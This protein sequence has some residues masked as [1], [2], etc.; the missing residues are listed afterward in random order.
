MNP[1]FAVV[2]AR[3]EP[4]DLEKLRRAFLGVP[5]LTPHDAD[6]VGGEGDAILCRNLSA[7]QA[8]ML[9]AKLQAEG[10]EVE[11][12]D[13][14]QL[15][16]LPPPKAIRRI[17]LTPEALWVDDLIKGKIPIAWRQV[18]LIGAG[19][20]QLMTVT[21]K[22]T[23]TREVDP[24]PLRHLTP[25]WPLISGRKVQF[26][27]QTSTDWFLRAEIVLAEG[28]VRYSI[29]AENFNFAPL[30]EGVSKDLAGNFCLLIRGLAAH[31]PEALLSRGA[32]S[33]L[34]DPCEFAYYSRKT[35]FEDDLIWTLWKA[36][37]SGG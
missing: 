8:A 2:Q 12:V 24:N 33:I 16:V 22:R 23:E 28:A 6:V 35:A 18:R 30:G 34:S 9:Q 21:R 14:S 5:G 4:L 32:A 36:Q 25:L 37:Q 17:E 7:D 3:R 27:S 20:V 1:R 13:Q 10:V 31:A 11:T 29:E 15:P 19:S 26:S